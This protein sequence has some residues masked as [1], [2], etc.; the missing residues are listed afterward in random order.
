MIAD[1]TIAPCRTDSSRNVPHDRVEARLLG[2]S[3]RRQQVV[4][5]RVRETTR[6]RCRLAVSATAC[7]IPQAVQKL[8]WAAPVAHR[9]AAPGAP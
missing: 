6:S 3:V 1:G 2:T 7:R 8:P 9:C 5:V 4:L